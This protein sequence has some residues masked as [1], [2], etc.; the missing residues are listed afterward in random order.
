M[1]DVDSETPD[2][3]LLVEDSVIRARG[4]G[5]VPSSLGEGAIEHD[6][7]GLRLTPGFIDLHVHGG[8]GQS[9]DDGMDAMS[10]ALAS[11]RAAGTTRSLISL[12]SASI[13]ELAA[14]L[15]E[16][17]ELTDRDPTVL[18]S[19][20]EGPFLAPARSGAHAHERLIEPSPRAIDALLSAARGTLRQITLA[21]ELPGALHLVERLAG[22]GVTVA[23]GHTAA[24]YATAGAAFERGATVLTHAFNAMPGLDARAPGPVGAAIDDPRVT[25]E[26]IVDGRHLHPAIVRLAFAAAPDRIALVTDAMAA[27][28]AG[29][30]VYRLGSRSVTVRAGRAVLTGTDT[31]AGSTLTQDA[32]LRF[33]LDAGIPPTSAVAALT[34]TPARVLGLSGRHG[35]LDAGC[36]ADLVVLDG[37]W[38]VRQVWIAGRQI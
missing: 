38:R 31:L 32:A 13:E 23:I 4:A 26:L 25:L 37:Q 16:V 2:G 1:I 34:A 33:A 22:N 8:G 27:A 21:P 18:G 12:V 3:W 19:H 11:H 20:L 15:S 6:L 29:D 5:A 28:G 36:I 14:R 17:A 24:D 30:G 10:A 9:F 7:D 35:S